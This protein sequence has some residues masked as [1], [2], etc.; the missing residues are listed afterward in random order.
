VLKV[1]GSLCCGEETYLGGIANLKEA[2]SSIEDYGWL[3]SC[4]SLVHYLEIAYQ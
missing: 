2:G 1:D 4:G 3:A